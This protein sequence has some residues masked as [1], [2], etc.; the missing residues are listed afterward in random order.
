MPINPFLHEDLH[1]DYNFED[2]HLGTVL[3]FAS[4]AINVD[5]IKVSHFSDLISHLTCPRSKLIIFLN[6]STQALNSMKSQKIHPEPTVLIW[7][8]S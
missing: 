4:R 2:V 6:R 5:H 8:M 7:S 3:N 1:S